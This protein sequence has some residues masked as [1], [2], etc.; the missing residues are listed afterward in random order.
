MTCRVRQIRR[1][2]WARTTRRTAQTDLESR[3][4]LA[5]TIFVVAAVL[6]RETA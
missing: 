5:P 2:V 6:A 3:V 1:F 4:K